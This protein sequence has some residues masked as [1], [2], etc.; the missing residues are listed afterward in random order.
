MNKKVFR[1]GSKLETYFSIQVH[2]KNAIEYKRWS[3]Q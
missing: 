2:K 1:N 3:P